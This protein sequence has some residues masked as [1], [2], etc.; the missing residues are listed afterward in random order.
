MEDLRA[1]LSTSGGRAFIW[2]LL[3]QTG[4]YQS[5]FQGDVN[6]G[7]FREGRRSIG[8]WTVGELAEANPNVYALMQSEA[9]TQEKNNG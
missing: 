5:S 7:I 1:I 2:R 9:V 4:M 6:D 8:L 3:E